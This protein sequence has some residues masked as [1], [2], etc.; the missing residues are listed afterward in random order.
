M[1][2][3]TIQG[4]T[5]IYGLVDPR[6][7]DV[8]RYVGQ[9]KIPRIRHIQHISNLES[10]KKSEWIESLAQ[11]GIF[12][13]MIIFLW[14]S[15]NKADDKEKEF[16]IKYKS[17]L[18]TNTNPPENVVPIQEQGMLK[19][20]ERNTIEAKLKEHRYN[21][22]AVAQLLGISRSTLYNKIKQYNIT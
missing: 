3:K 16:I 14:V 15:E 8:I 2:P 10:S 1:Q 9:S 17:E 13:Q 21:K 6:Q 12:P 19:N 20:N 4:Q 5:A 22:Q 18:L 11:N 7:P